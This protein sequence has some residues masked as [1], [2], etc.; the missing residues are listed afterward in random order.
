MV[1][2]TKETKTLQIITMLRSIQ[3]T[4]SQQLPAQLIENVMAM[5]R[6]SELY[7]PG[8]NSLTEDPEALGFMDGLMEVRVYLGLFRYQLALGHVGFRNEIVLLYDGW[9]T[10]GLL[11]G[12]RKC[13]T[14][15]FMLNLP[16]FT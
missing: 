13:C 1:Q 4:G 8:S 12:Q 10:T 3:D 16:H 5:L 2:Q 7:N 11:F 9:R 6:S 15:N 14:S